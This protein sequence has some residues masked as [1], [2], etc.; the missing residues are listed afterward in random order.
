MGARKF[1]KVLSPQVRSMCRIEGF[2]MLLLP[3]T[4]SSYA[5]LQFSTDP[6]S[7]ERK[8]ESIVLFI[9]FSLLAHVLTL[10]VVA[11][12]RVWHRRYIGQCSIM[13]RYHHASQ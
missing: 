1:R 7:R 6:T 12:M 9:I 13:E 5:T 3:V 8:Y 2:P 4:I 10:V 11:Q